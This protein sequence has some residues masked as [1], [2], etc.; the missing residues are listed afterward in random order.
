MA[1]LRDLPHAHECPIVAIESMG[2][3]RRQVHNILERSIAVILLNA[4][5]VKNMPGPLADIKDSVT[6]HTFHDM[7]DPVPLISLKNQKDVFVSFFIEQF[8]II[9]PG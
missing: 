7:A 2:V 4:R 8:Q 1:R 3:Y 6:I 5:L 9:N